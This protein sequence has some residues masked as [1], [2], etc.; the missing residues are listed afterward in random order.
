MAT[1]PIRVSID[2][3]AGPQMVWAGLTRPEM[4]KQYLFGTDLKTTW[5][6]GSPITFSGTY[7]GKAYEDGGTVLEV[8]PEAR[9][10]Y[11]YWSSM[12]GLPNTPEHQQ[13]VAFDLE[14][15]GDDTRLIL[16]QSNL[17]SEQAREHS[18]SNW[19]MVLNGL[20]ALVETKGR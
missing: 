14:P 1:E 12:S 9:L 16:T 2:I 7:E 8:T 18:A 6:V 11:T 13:I 17:P 15:R 3:H 4:V 5:A 19:Q 10:A 20:K